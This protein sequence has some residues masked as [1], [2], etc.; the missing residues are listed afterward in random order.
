MGNCFV[1]NSAKIQTPSKGK[2]TNDAKF[3]LF[4]LYNFQEREFLKQQ[5]ES[6]EKNFFNNL[7]EKSFLNFTFKRKE[8]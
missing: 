1:E 5:S 8:T 7:V 3:S 4:N 2:E 6:M